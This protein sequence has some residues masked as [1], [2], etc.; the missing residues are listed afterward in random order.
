M[1]ESNSVKEVNIRIAKAT[2]ALVKLKLVW[3]GRSVLMATQVRLLQTLVLSVLYAAETRT[4][5][6]E[7]KKRISAFEMNSY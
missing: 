7:I 5:N 3:Y 1:S 2:N 4:L 6:A